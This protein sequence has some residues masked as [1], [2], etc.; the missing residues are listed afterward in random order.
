MILCLCFWLSTPELESQWQSANEAYKSGDFEAAAQTYEQL[1]ETGA[2]NGPLHFNIG[3][4]YLKQGLLGKALVHFYRA[5]R[6]MPYDSDL[7]H[8]LSYANQLRKDPVIDEEEDAFLRGLDHVVNA[9]DAR[10]PFYLALICWIMAGIASMALIIQRQK[11]R[12]ASYTMV[13]AG[14]L[15]VL[16]TGLSF[17]QYRQLARH[18]FAIVVAQELQVMAGPSR[19]EAV[20][21]TVHEGIRC[22]IMGE[23]DDWVRVRL[24]NGYNGWVPRSKVE[25]I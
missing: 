12:R 23:S 10:I 2:N 21:F 15:A 4:A 13:I 25:R 9:V 11:T 6:Y 8:N 16:I 14:I 19:R 22:Q 20:S 17:V 24:A 5:E 1:L 7:A 3:N 18:D